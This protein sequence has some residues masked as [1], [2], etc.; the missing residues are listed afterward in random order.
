MKSGIQNLVS[1]AKL[2]QAID[3]ALRMYPSKEDTLILLKSRYNTLSRN[4]NLNLLSSSDANIER[5]RISSALLSTC[6][7]S[8]GYDDVDVMVVRA[9]SV[10]QSVSADTLISRLEKVSQ[11]CQ[12]R[13]RDISKNAENL[14]DELIEYKRKKRQSPVFDKD[15]D[16]LS[17]FSQK[18]S[19]IEADFENA[20]RK[21]EVNTAEKIFK[22]LEGDLTKE[23]IEKAYG[24][25]QSKGYQ[26]RFIDTQLNNSITSDD[27]LEDCADMLDTFARSL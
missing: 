26:N 25:A 2:G 21:K 13:N 10:N 27:A 6:D 14:I 5:S 7:D 3:E 11:N 24:W 9:V 16:Q 20:E 1:Q 17:E 22:E 8:D 12:R 15:S 19:K 23:K 18:V 4:T